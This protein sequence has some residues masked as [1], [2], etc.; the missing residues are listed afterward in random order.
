MAKTHIEGF[1]DYLENSLRAYN[2]SG[3]TDREKL[4]FNALYHA[5]RYHDQLKRHDT[6][7]M[8]QTVSR[9]MEDGINM[10]RKANENAT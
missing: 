7:M 2:S 5:L 3:W 6:R 8:E 10:E 1:P 4:L 9:A